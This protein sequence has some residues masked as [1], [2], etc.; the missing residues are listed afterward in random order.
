MVSRTTP[1]FGNLFNAGD[2]RGLFQFLQFENKWPIY[3]LSIL[4]YPR[5]TQ[6]EPNKI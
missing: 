2:F 3:I 5:H 1:Y 6:Q 4:Q